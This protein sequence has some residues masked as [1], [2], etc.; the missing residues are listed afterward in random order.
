MADVSAVTSSGSR[1]GEGWTDEPLL[2]GEI[3]TSS[4]SRVGESVENNETRDDLEVVYE[5]EMD[6]LTTTRPEEVQEMDVDQ[7]AT[8]DTTSNAG[9]SDTTPVDFGGLPISASAA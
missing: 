5:T 3:P 9:Q 7:D 1:V 2:R 6:N 4:G 8:P